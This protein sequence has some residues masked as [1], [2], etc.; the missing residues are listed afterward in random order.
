VATTYTTAGAVKSNAPYFTDVQGSDAGGQN[1]VTIELSVYPPMAGTYTCGT[2]GVGLLISTPTAA[3][4]SGVNSAAL[5]QGSQTSCAITVT[6]YTAA[7]A[8]LTGTFSG[9]L[10]KANTAGSTVVITNGHFQV[11]AP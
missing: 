3:F 9:T 2:N 7:G 6:S 5:T 8:P 11:T 10:G 4:Y 1:F